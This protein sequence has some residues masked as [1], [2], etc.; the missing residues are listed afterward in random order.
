LS[1]LEGWVIQ[2]PS[3]TPDIYGHLI[4]STEERTAELMEELINPILIGGIAPTAP[5]LHPIGSLP[6]KNH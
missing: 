2:K 6:I 1:Y 4:P 5:E 3:I